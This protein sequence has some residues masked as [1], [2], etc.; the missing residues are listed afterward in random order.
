MEA[1]TLSPTSGNLIMFPHWVADFNIACISVYMVEKTI[2]FSGNLLTIIAIAKYEKLSQHPSNI[3]IASLAA[4]DSVNFLAAAP[5]FLVYSNLL[6]M[7]KPEQLKIMNIACYIV[8][9]FNIVSFY[10]N[11][12][13]IFVIAME[14]FLSVNF[15]L[16]MK[17]KLT[18]GKAKIVCITLWILI[19]LKLAGDFIFFNSG[20]GFPFCLWR[21]AFKPK[22]YIYSVMAPFVA[23]SCGTLLLYLR[24]AHV[25][26]KRSQRYMVSIIF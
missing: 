9:V 1:G 6:N 15:P 3:F 14:R 20:L 12:C 18:T 13:H 24:I 7:Q 4:A 11:F 26:C 25:A 16:L 23:I 10:G 21:L 22:H 2:G 8:C 5:E 19:A 17:T